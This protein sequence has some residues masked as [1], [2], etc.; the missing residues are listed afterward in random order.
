MLAA[1]VLRPAAAR[2]F[3]S[4]AEV[5]GI[6]GRYATALYN[7]ATKNK[8]LAAVSADLTTF[9]N[10][11]ASNSEF[12]TVLSDPS[13]SKESK[14]A[15]VGAI[16]EQAGLKTDTINFFKVAADNGRIA[17]ADKMISDFRLLV[18]QDSDSVTA[19]VTTATK[20]SAGQKKKLEKALKSK[21][22]I[23]GALTIEENVD[24]TILGGMI[25]TMD[26]TMIDAS[27]LTKVREMKMTIS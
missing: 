15:A 13:V 25:V 11:R 2:G 6:G 5:F 21:V 4:K 17:S 18:A 20:M 14:S 10:L 23:S 12:D 8:S 24:A 19:K 27:T 16:L 26:D 7:V 3:A 9:E 1:K 22:G